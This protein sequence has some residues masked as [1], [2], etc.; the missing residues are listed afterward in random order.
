MPRINIKE[1]GLTPQ[2]A[3]D[4]FSNLKPD[5][6]AKKVEELK[7]VNAANASTAKT[8]TDKVNQIK[9]LQKDN[10]G[11]AAAVGS[12]MFSRDESNQPGII[13][14]LKGM[15]YNVI[16]PITSASN[17]LTGAKS[18]Y[19][20]GVQQLTNQET[21]NNLLQLKQ[22]GGT[23]GALNESEGQMLRDAATKINNWAVKD[24]DGNVTGYNTSEEN[25]NA[26]LQRLR[27]LAQ[28][29]VDKAKGVSTADN[30]G[31]TSGGVKYTIE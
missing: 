24:A 13:N 31:V 17:F 10:G 20:A 28:K 6:I 22:A 15:I 21:L 26:E 3:Q 1:L 27:D 11:E 7:A 5:E 4:T 12:N 19:V 29:A 14:S 25:F 8:F 16:H 30:S 9:G 2:Q 18:N 23:L